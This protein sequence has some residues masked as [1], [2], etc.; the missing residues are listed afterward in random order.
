MKRYWILA[1]LPLLLLG[2][3]YLWREA[4]DPVQACASKAEG[5]FACYWD[6]LL[7]LVEKGDYGKA[8]SLCLKAKDPE[9]YRAYGASV[10]DRSLCS[11]LRLEGSGAMILCYYHGVRPEDFSDSHRGP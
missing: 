7:P 6:V 4:K 10:P 8:A 1:L 5:A 3:V 2:G 11:Y 9:C